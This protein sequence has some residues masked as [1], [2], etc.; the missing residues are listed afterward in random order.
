MSK[1]VTWLCFVVT[2]SLAGCGGRDYEGDQRYAVSG[3][4]TVDGQP[5]HPGHIGF[6]PQDGSTEIR[7]ANAPIREGKYSITEA[8][9]PNAGTYRVEIHWNKPTGK[10]I[11]DMTR[12]PLNP[13]D[14]WEMMPELVE[15]LPAKYHRNSELTATV[16]EDQTTFDYELQTK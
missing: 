2:V 15:G 5:L 13:G 3:T 6:Y 16:S 9:G 14:P 11:R 12:A 10:Q 7:P 1:Y 4:V 8:Q